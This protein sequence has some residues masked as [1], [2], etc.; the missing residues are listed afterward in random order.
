MNVR[1]LCLGILA[2]EDAS[3]YEIKKAVEDG[4]FA[5][6]IDASYGSIYPAL[7]QMLTDG[8]VSVREESHPGKPPKKVYSITSSGRTAL[9]KALHV[10]PRQDKFKSEFL[11]QALFKDDLTPE[12]L[13]EVFEGQMEYLH[14][15]L[16]QIEE[17]RQ[18]AEPGSGHMFVNGYGQAVLR[19]AIEYMEKA[20]GELGLQPQ[21][22]ARDAAE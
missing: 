19:A 8:H 22:P 1:T 2:H 7:T 3:G 21:G 16:A 12:H 13:A 9:R 20:R 11:F 5:H 14:R 18:Q 6:F 10:T 4:M 17:C 15:E